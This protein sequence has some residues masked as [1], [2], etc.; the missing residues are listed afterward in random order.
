[1]IVHA[2]GYM[3]PSVGIVKEIRVFFAYHHVGWGTGSL[4]NRYECVLIVNQVI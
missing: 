3:K 2:K 1:M 4:T